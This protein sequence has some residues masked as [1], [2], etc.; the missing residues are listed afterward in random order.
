M[1]FRSSKKPNALV[2]SA[3]TSALWMPS[4]MYVLVKRFS[5]KEERRRVVAAVF[6][7]SLVS[8][9]VV[10][11]ENHLNVFHEEGHGLRPALAR[12]LAAFLNSTLVDTYFR[13]FNGHTQVNATDLRN[14]KYPTAAVLERLGEVVGRRKQTQDE[15]DALV[16]E[17]VNVGNS[18]KT[19]DPI[20]AKKR[21]DEALA[22]LKAL[23]LPREQQNERSALTLLSLLDLKPSTP[24]KD[25]SAPLLGIT[26]MM[27]FFSERYGKT[28]APNSR[29]TVRRF[30]VHQFIEAGIV[31]PNPDKA[32]PVNS[33]NAV[34]QI[35]KGALRLLRGFGG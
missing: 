23:G 24:W 10:G 16:E 32:R 20:Q 19:A 27:T 8:S 7:P 12:G 21:V 14:L 9:S 17:L 26:P 4:G 11:F 33:P 5:S 13:Q 15:L 22:V 18:S 1:L 3:E 34:Y 31:I 25:A 6:D 30:T 28:Y 2:V 35:E 29:E